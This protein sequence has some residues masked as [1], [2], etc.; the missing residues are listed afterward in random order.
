MTMQSFHISIHPAKNDFNYRNPKMIQIYIWDA[1]IDG[2]DKTMVSPNERI[3]HGIVLPLEFL[4][5]ADPHFIDYRTFRLTKEKIFLW[6]IFPTHAD[7]W[8]DLF[9]G[10]YNSIGLRYQEYPAGKFSSNLREILASEILRNR[11]LFFALSWSFSQIQYPDVI[12]ELI[13]NHFVDKRL[14]L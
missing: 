1:S 11:N 10:G 5:V 7:A 8:F 2:N 14:P 3:F 6:K 4:D 12:S 13:K 9:E